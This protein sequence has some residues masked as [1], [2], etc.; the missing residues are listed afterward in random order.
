MGKEECCKH[1][2]SRAGRHPSE[3]VHHVCARLAL[4]TVAAHPSGAPFASMLLA[5]AGRAE[6]PCGE[7]EEQAA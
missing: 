2:G 7:E 6:Q 5:G 4:L 3:C 1:S